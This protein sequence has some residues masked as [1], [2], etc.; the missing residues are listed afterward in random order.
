MQTGKFVSEDVEDQTEQVNKIFANS[1]GNI[2][3]RYFTILC[4]LSTFDYYNQ[5]IMLVYGCPVSYG[6]NV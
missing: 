3:I 4:C 6:L 1:H 2:I 5:E